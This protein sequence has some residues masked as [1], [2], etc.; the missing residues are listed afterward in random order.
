MTQG[1]QI[2]VKVPSFIIPTRSVR[3][4]LPTGGFD[5]WRESVNRAKAVCWR[6][7]SSEVGRSGCGRKD[8][9][10]HGVFLRKLYSPIK[11]NGVSFG[12]RI[13]MSKERAPTWTC[14][15]FRA[16]LHYSCHRGNPRYLPTLPP[17][18]RPPPPEWP[19]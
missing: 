7:D 1:N 4:L 12:P 19:R 13:T 8:P 17:V 2:R 5:P 16:R 14:R 15:V 10:L 6:C 9:V 3:C 11:T 18:P